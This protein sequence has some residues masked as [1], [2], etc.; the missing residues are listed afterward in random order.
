[1]HSVRLVDPYKIRFTKERL[2]CCDDCSPLR[3]PIGSRDPRIRTHIRFGWKLCARRNE[4][5][6]A[7]INGFDEVDGSKW[8]RSHRN[9]CRCRCRIIDHDCTQIII[10]DGY[11][12]ARCCEHSA[13]IADV[14]RVH[15][16]Y[17]KERER[18]RHNKSN[19]LRAIENISLDTAR[20]MVDFA[21]FPADRSNRSKRHHGLFPRTRCPKRA[22][23]CGELLTRRERDTRVTRTSNRMRVSWWNP[24]KITGTTIF[25]FSNP[26]L[27]CSHRIRTFREQ[28]FDEPI[29]CRVEFERIRAVRCQTSEESGATIPDIIRHEERPRTCA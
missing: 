19:A 4:R 13:L 20:V 18:C 11:K 2:C 25:N 29:D 9:D 17:G 27:R 21:N 23:H 12:N 10:V 16:I 1:M 8:N 28:T 14:P 6:A 5:P 3:C 26:A 15:P 22:Q 24:P 7:P